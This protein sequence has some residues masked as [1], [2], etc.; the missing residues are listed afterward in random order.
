MVSTPF[1]FLDRILGLGPRAKKERRMADPE[2]SKP[3]TTALDAVMGG[4][5]RILANMQ[6]WETKEYNF[7][8]IMVTKEKSTPSYHY[9]KPVTSDERT[10]VKLAVPTDQKLRAYCHT[11]PKGVASGNFSPEDKASFIKLRKQ[12]PTVKVGWYLM[13]ASS[14]GEL[15]FAIEE[16]MF[17][18]GTRV[19]LDS[20]IA[21]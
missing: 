5:N 16:E 6:D 20:S 7:A 3:Y 12:M 9:S 1:A 8:V 17:M 15:R 14:Q 18:A 11:H 10:G 21:P 19:T 2:L 4:F 13:N